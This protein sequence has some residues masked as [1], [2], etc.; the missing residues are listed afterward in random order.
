MNYE[1][2]KAGEINMPQNSQRMTKEQ[3]M[4]EVKNFLNVGKQLKLSEFIDDEFFAE[5]SEME[6]G[7]QALEK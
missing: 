3:E 4:E 5:D 2:L 6:E 7:K 1:Q